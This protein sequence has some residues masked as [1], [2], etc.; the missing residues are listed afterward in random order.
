M[1]AATAIKPPRKNPIGNHHS[2]DYLARE[3]PVSGALNQQP[4]IAQSTTFVKPTN[5]ILLVLACTATNLA[6]QPNHCPEE[7][8]RAAAVRERIE[9]DWPLRRPDAVTEY[10][11]NFG[12][13]LAARAGIGRV[14]NW[15]FS[16]VQDTSI[17][18]YSIGDGQ[19]YITEG[20]I[21]AAAD[22]SE[23]AAV[24]GHEMGHDIAGHL[25]PR[26]EKPGESPWWD[27]FSSS[28][29]TRPEQRKSLSYQGSLHQV[30]DP[31]KEREANRNAA[32]ILRKAGY[33]PGAI[34]RIARR[35][36]ERE[37]SRE[38]GQRRSHLSYLNQQGRPWR[39]PDSMG[40]IAIGD[41]SRLHE[42]QQLLRENHQ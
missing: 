34:L 30:I 31:S 9:R 42:I 20:A 36:A 23:L 18:A 12:Y 19:I 29:D 15:R 21:V 4:A 14:S 11:D 38:G 28:S 1:P 3:P 26:A 33:D 17:N 35:I 27:I 13:Q 39:N 25:C 41:A 22:E 7:R 40:E 2:T 16:V 10:I 24:L 32:V 5:I 8:Q 6:A 37:R